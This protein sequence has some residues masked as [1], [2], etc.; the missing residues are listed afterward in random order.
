MNE[1]IFFR[2]KGRQ[3][4]F[5]SSKKDMATHIKYN[6]FLITAFLEVGYFLSAYLKFFSLYSKFYIL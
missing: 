4:I 1:N 3:H 2:R 5:L 6:A